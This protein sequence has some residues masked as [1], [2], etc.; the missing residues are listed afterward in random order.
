MYIYI[1]SLDNLY[2]VVGMGRRLMLAREKCFFIHSC[3]FQNTGI[4]AASVVSGQLA[5]QP[6]PFSGADT[7]PVAA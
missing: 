2:E 3:F 7:E 4:A 6:G 1:L 5:R